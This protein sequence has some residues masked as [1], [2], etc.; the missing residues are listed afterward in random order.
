MAAI[1]VLAAGVPLLSSRTGVM[2]Q[3]QEADEMLFAPA[4]PDQLASALNRLFQDWPQL[5]LGVTR[6][7]ENIRRRFLI[8]Q[9]VDL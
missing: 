3:V 1:E 2:E 6:S 7:Q 9:T 8:D 5:D 4:K